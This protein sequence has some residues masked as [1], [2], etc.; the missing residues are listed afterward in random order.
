MRVTA[1]IALV[2]MLST[3]AGAAAGTHVVQRGETLSGI[4]GRNGVSVGALVAANGLREPNRVAAGQRLVIP[5]SDPARTTALAS[6]GGVSGYHVVQRGETLASI[7]RQ[8]GVAASTIAA[9]NGLVD[10]CVY[11][12]ARLRL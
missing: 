1:T 2:G 11:T 8:H 4:A 7:A 12:G 5:G 10:G 6:P 3:G 9:A